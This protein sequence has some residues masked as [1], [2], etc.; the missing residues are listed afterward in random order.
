MW[1]AGIKP[2]VQVMTTGE[3]AGSLAFSY[4]AGI[5]LSRRWIFDV[6]LVKDDIE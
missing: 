6:D 2:G 4:E 1:F 5:V 3:K